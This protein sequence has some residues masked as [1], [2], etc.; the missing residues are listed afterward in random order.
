[1]HYLLHWPDRSCTD[2]GRG[3][4]F[5]HFCE[6]SLPVITSYRSKKS[7]NVGSKANL[8]RTNSFIQVCT[9]LKR[10]QLKRN[11]RD[12]IQF[13]NIRTSTKPILPRIVPELPISSML[14]KN[15]L[16]VIKPWRSCNMDFRSQ[17]ICRRNFVRRMRLDIDMSR[18]R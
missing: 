7:P 13:A 17:R 2:R 15:S 16:E 9:S 11:V 10:P 4:L 5:L 1:V 3:Q 18:M 8:W 14:L 12:Q 6:I